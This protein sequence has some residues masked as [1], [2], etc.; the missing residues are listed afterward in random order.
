MRK[1]IF[2]LAAC[3]LLSPLSPEIREE[4]PETAAACAVLL[5]PQGQILYERNAQSP[6]LIASTTKLM[7]ALVTLEHAA[8]EDR[9]EIPAA[10]CEVEGSSM[11]LRAG[12]SYTVEEL[13]Q[14]LLLASG[15]DAAL[16]LALHCAGDEGRFVAWMNEK[17]E[18][19][20]MAHS[21]FANPHGLDALEH[22]G[23]AADLG[24]LMLRCMERPELARILSTP[25]VQIRG[26]SYVNHNKLLWRCPGCLGGKTGYTMAAGRCLVSCCE[27]EGTRLVCVTLSDPEDWDD[28]CALYDW[29]FAHWTQRSVTGSLR[30]TL[31]VYGGDAPLAELAA[32]PLPLFLPKDAVLRVRVELPPFALAPLRRGETC[33]RV[34]V[35]RDGEVLGSA[36]L[37][38]CQDVAPENKRRDP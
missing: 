2:A 23:S 9:V 13:L 4:P 7:T 6:A 21:R 38:F 22:Y 12:E 3:L 27:R 15:N 14:G 29:G 5:G 11:Y 10:C 19:L 37:R 31:P 30:Y 8:L 26:E 28:H 16:A 36:A 32:D 33:G 35:L 34:T 20:G 18:E 1:A 25:S 17:A 24:L